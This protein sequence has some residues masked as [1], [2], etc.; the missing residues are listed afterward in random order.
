MRLTRLSGTAII[1]VIL[2]RL[3]SRGLLR[4]LGF[5]REPSRLLLFGFRKPE[6]KDEL[7]KEKSP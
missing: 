4:G 1:R 5:I 6:F 2:M 7:E 3:N